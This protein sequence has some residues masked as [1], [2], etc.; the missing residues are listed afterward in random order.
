MLKGTV[1]ILLSIVSYMYGGL[2]KKAGSGTRFYRTW[3]YISLCLLFFGIIFITGIDRYIP[4]AVFKVLTVLIVCGALVAVIILIYILSGIKG[5]ERKGLDA[6][7]VLGSQIRE[8]GPS[9]SLLFRLQEA[10][11]YLKEN[12]QTLCIVTGGQGYNEPITEAEGMKSYLVENG[13]GEDRIIMEDRATTTY[14]NLLF[15]SAFLDRKNDHV[16]IVTNNF[17]I[18]R[19][20]CIARK[21]GYSHVCGIAGY[22]MPSFLPNN[23]LREVLAFGLDILRGHIF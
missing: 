14:E 16:G 5:S 22:S 20:I 23:L 15:S 10:D 21:L 9:K 8:D 7:V 12:P 17:H 11:R 4:G 18:K 13:I 19:S 6:L 1:L 3:Y 2:I